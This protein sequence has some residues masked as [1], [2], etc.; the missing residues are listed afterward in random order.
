MTPTRIVLGVAAI[1]AALILSLSVATG[2]TGTKVAV[3]DQ[4]PDF[5]LRD[6]HGDW[7]TLSDYRGKWVALYFYPKDDTPGC[8]TEACS[9]RDN[10][11]AFRKIGAE[12]VGVSLDD[13]ASHKEFAEK[14]SL[15]F[16]L[17]ADTDGDAARSYGVLSK[18]GYARRETFLIDPNGAVAKHYAKVDPET[19][20]EEILADL[21][22]LQ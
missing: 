4:A 9:F 22:Q 8:T 6:Q 11:F 12:I 10:I 3:S 14:Y 16:T 15:P 19:H 2:N 1:A 21:K 7:H 20:S 17:L 5:R 18:L 13:S